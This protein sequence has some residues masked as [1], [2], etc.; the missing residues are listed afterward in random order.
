MFSD[1]LDRV[2]ESRYMLSAAELNVA[3]RTSSLHTGRNLH[4]AGHV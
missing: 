3:L 4:G 2:T 1:N